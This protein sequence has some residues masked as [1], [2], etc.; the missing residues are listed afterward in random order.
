[1]TV[2][3]SCVP[4]NFQKFLAKKRGEEWIWTA[5]LNSNQCGRTSVPPIRIAYKNS[6]VVSAVVVG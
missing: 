5:Q 4:W 2:V 6:A 3:V 1:M